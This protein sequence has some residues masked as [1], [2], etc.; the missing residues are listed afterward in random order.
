MF[1]QFG[2]IRI[3]WVL[4]WLHIFVHNLLMHNYTYKYTSAHISK[5]DDLVLQA[6]TEAGY[7]EGSKIDVCSLT[8]SFV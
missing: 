4:K 1:L 3:F 2:Q 7:R 6:P 5:K 8:L